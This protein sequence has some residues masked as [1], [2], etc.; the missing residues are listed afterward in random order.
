MSLLGMLLQGRIKNDHQGQF[1]ESLKSAHS[2]KDCIIQ[3]SIRLFYLSKP[4]NLL[5]FIILESLCSFAY[6]KWKITFY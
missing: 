3:P 6:M 2:K 4:K 5:G 1:S